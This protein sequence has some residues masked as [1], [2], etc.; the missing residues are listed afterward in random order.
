MTPAGTWNRFA[1]IVLPIRVRR[2]GSQTDSE[3]PKSH[4]RWYSFLERHVLR[5]AVLMDEDEKD[6]VRDFLGNASGT[7][8]EVGA[9]EPVSKS[10]TYHLELTGWSGVLVEPVIEFA[11]GLRRARRAAVFAVA[12]GAPEDDGN[13][14]QFLVAGPL[15]TLMPPRVLPSWVPKDFRNVPTRTLNSILT[16]A[17]IGNL[18]FLSIDVEGAE[19]DVLRGIS[20]DRYR[21]RLILLEDHVLDRSKHRFMASNG[22]KLVRR[23]GLNNW[24]VPKQIE[25]AISLLGRIQLMRRLYLGLFLR[26]YR[27]SRRRA[28]GELLVTG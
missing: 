16:E 22:Y 18:D 21:P 20:L 12:A 25:F 9:Y 4:W 2:K 10:Q 5:P 3:R 15:S 8:A 19:L 27:Y 17:G 26:H 11:E 23:T 14:R 7:F 1:L 13:E 28:A 24:Y 6:L